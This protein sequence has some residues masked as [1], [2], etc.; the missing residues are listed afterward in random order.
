MSAW[1]DYYSVD[2]SLARCA[3][4]DPDS[5]FPDDRGNPIQSNAVLGKVCESCPILVECANYA[6]KHEQRGFWG[7]LSA[8]ARRYIRIENNLD[9]PTYVSPISDRQIL[10]ARARLAKDR[11]D[12]DATTSE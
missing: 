2:W 1:K 10:A 8:Y 4:V 6:V 11:G 9:E 7:G 12:I 5:F 3:G